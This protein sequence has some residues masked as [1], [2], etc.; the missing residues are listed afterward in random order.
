MLA[1]IIAEQV[2]NVQP[3]SLNQSPLT[4]DSENHNIAESLKI[5]VFRG[6]GTQPDKEA[7]TCKNV[8][9]PV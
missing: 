5:G 6:D 1:S 8:K 4:F 7:D 2:S 9:E 3:F